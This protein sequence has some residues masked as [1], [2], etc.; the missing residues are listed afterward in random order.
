MPR[1]HR[2]VNLLLDRHPQYNLLP[3]WCPHHAPPQSRYFP[4]LL[5]A[6]RYLRVYR[7]LSGAGRCLARPEYRQ[8]PPDQSLS[9]WL[10]GFLTD[11]LSPLQ[12]SDNPSLH[13]SKILFL[14][15]FLLKFAHLSSPASVSIQDDLKIPEVFRWKEK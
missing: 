4:D 12:V 5:D 15:V 3:S 9:V 11:V 14:L 13:P 10:D 7:Y 6:L 2:R 1:S 8:L